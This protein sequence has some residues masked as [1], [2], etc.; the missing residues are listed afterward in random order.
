[1]RCLARQS[2]YRKANPPSRLLVGSLASSLRPEVLSAAGGQWPP[3]VRLGV[4]TVV[5]GP[6]G[7]RRAGRKAAASAEGSE[8]TVKASAD[9]GGGVPCRERKGQSHVSSG[10]L[11]VSLQRFLGAGVWLE[12]PVCSTHSTPKTKKEK[13]HCQ[14][15]LTLLRASHARPGRGFA[16]WGRGDVTRPHP[17]ASGAG[18]PLCCFVG[19][20]TAGQRTWTEVLDLLVPDVTI[21]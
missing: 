5:R 20:G 16:V 17:G 11:T 19:L 4:R 21:W 6:R 3:W 18:R 12:G 15:F 10:R 14:P 13:G 9:G 7:G 2:L 8:V 1:V